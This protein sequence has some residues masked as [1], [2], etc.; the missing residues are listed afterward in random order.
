[1]PEV[2]LSQDKK[3]KKQNPWEKFDVSEFKSKNVDPDGII[4]KLRVLTR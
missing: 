4:T 2:K 1:M 3:K